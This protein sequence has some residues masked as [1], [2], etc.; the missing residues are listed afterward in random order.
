LVVNS[1]ICIAVSL[2]SNQIWFRLGATGPWNSST[3]NGNPV[4]Y[5]DSGY[6]GGLSAINT[7][8][9]LTPVSL[10][11]VNSSDSVTFNFGASPFVGAVPTGFINGWD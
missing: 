8:S 1:V 2:T 9:G 7:G 10:M 5:S 6:I 3:N 4:G 11:A